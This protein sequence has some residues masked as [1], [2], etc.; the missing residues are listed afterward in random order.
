MLPSLHGPRSNKL[1]ADRNWSCIGLVILMSAALCA[2]ASASY[3]FT[4]IEQVIAGVEGDTTAQ[5]IQIRMR[6]NGQDQMQLAKLVAWDA[7]GENPV[8]LIDFAS[9]VAVAVA[10]EHVLAASSRFASYTQPSAVPDFIFENLIPQSYLGAGSITMENDEET[11][12]V[13][14]LSWGGAN[15]L[16]STQ[17]ALTNDDDRDFG[18]PVPDALPIDGLEALQFQGAFDAKSTTN[19]SDYALTD[20]AAVFTNNGGASFTVTPLQCPNDPGNDEDGDRV[21]GEVD[22]CPLVA[23][24]DQTDSDGDGFGDVCD[25]C[26]LDPQTATDAALCAGSGGGTDGT[27]GTGG[28]DPGSGD[29][30]GS[31]N[32]GSDG[33]T[34]GDATGADGGTTPTTP[35]ACGFSF[36]ALIAMVAV[37]S[38]LP[39]RRGRSH[40]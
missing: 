2:E 26:P 9:A 6:S 17:A 37:L 25:A 35:R 32:T 34:G 36:P 12:L 1:N 38:V 30:T 5:A 20:G 7:N 16:G 21:C 10:G 39:I 14:R 33:T 31:D 22:N 11:L 8:V 40:G 29:G 15:Y 24:F 4:Q 28:S 13:W 27:P 23:N 3:H 19:A 18:P